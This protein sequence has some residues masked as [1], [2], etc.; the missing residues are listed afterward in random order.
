MESIDNKNATDKA[1]QEDERLKQSNEPL[2][3]EKYKKKCDCPHFLLKLYEILENKDY[4]DII[5]WSEDG[6]YF[7]VQNLHDFTEKI[8]P[9]Y[10]KHNNFSSFIRQLNMYD[11]HKKKSSQNE[12]IF[13]HNNFI[14]D[15]K[16]LIKT[17]KRKSKKE[18]IP[19]NTYVP[20][21]K[22]FNTKQTNLIPVSNINLFNNINNGI[23]TSINN[24]KSSLSIDDDLNYTN[25]VHSLFES[26]PRPLLP[27]GLPSSPCENSTKSNNINGNCNSNNINS[28]NYNNFSNALNG[29]ATGNVNIN[30]NAL[31]D[32]K[33]VT[34]KNLQHLL[35]YLMSSIEENTEKEK[36][37]ELKI[38]RLSKQNEEFITQNQKILQEIIS[39]GDYNKK[40]EA[41]ICFILE[42]FMSK[43][44]IKS[45]SEPKNLFLSN[46]SSNKFPNI[47]KINKLDN[48]GIVNFS[49]SQ[50]NNG[51]LSQ[52]DF[53]S[54]SD[55]GLEPFQ[56]FLNKYLDKK[57]N[58]GLLTNIESNYNNNKNLLRDIEENKY[59][60][61]CSGNEDAGQNSNTQN[62]IPTSTDLICKKRKRSASF[63]SIL[64]N[65]SGGT[66][67]IY[68]SSYK[69]KGMGNE[70]IEE[71]EEK[72][73]DNEN[74]NV[75][76]SL[77]SDLLNNS[78]NKSKNAFDLDLNQEE[79][80]SDFSDWNKDL[81]NNSQSSINDIYNSSNINKD[82]EF[83][84]LN[85]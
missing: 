7:I 53:L 71:V 19:M 83:S 31:N 62:N 61:I 25:S 41:V 49:S 39:K 73:M 43:P 55:A 15:R 16:D 32:D 22:I 27:M 13:H 4:K 11:F 42:M 50:D 20:N 69:N 45:N 46:E 28:N 37:L 68:D 33:K 70:N 67:V 18:N 60:I 38:E 17:I 9:K 65:L 75:D 35:T 79:S 30:F 56:N 6:K 58:T 24:R 12:H 72:K 8:L 54:T 34:K 84:D 59:P 78:W 21:N 26:N 10:Y 23:N 63:N 74:I 66:N 5:H 52:N 14:K 2:L 1:I 57:K 81:L 82:N 64:S 80:K 76:N 47:S 36:Q 51:I 40:L 48:L 29:N 3:T 85:N 77:N 44:K